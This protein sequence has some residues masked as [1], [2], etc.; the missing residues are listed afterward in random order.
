VTPG[1]AANISG[2]TDNI[3]YAGPGLSAT[4]AGSPNMPKNFSAFSVAPK[5]AI[6]AWMSRPTTYTLSLGDVLSGVSQATSGFFEQM[7]RGLMQ[8]GPK[9]PSQRQ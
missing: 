3:N 7:Y 6:G 4:Y 5:A 8:Y 9:Y 1:P 2:V